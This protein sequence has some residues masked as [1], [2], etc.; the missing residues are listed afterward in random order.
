METSRIGF[1]G[2]PDVASRFEDEGFSVVTGESV[3]AS[4]KAIREALS[5]RSPSDSPLPVIVEDQ[6][7]TGL[8][9]LLLRFQRAAGDAAIVVVRSDEEVL[10]HDWTDIPLE[11]T[12]LEYARAAGITDAPG[13][14]A[15]LLVQ[16]DGSVVEV[17][18]D[19]DEPGLDD[20]DF[21]DEPAEPSLDDIDFGD[22][23]PV[24]AAPATA[25]PAPVAPVEDE[26]DDPF[27][28]DEPEPAPRR[29]STAPTAPSPAPAPAQPSLS[30][31]IF[32]AEEGLAGPSDDGDLRGATSSP[33]PAPRR[34][35]SPVP[36]IEEEDLDAE[37][38]PGEIGRPEEESA[39]RTRSGISRHEEVALSPSAR[40]WEVAQDDAPARPADDG[41]GRPRRRVVSA[42]T[43]AAEDP[44]GLSAD[45]SDDYLD[46]DSDDPDFADALVDEDDDDDM[47][48]G[49][50]ARRTA[51]SRARSARGRAPVIFNG[52][53]KGGVGK[54]LLTISLGQ[55]AA[56]RGQGMDVCV[57]D[58]NRGQG[59]VSTFLKLRRSDLPT[60]FEAAQVGDVTKAFLS[61]S[62][63]E[64][65]RGD[66]A[67]H[68]RFTLVSAPR[69]N[70][71]AESAKVVTD[72]TY[73]QVIDYARDNFDLVI[74]DTQIVES[75]D[76][77]GLIDGVVLPLLAE[78]AYFL[79]ITD[80]SRAGTDNLVD[81][82]FRRFPELGERHFGGKIAPR[83]FM[84][85]VNRMG[86]DVD[87]EGFERKFGKMSNFAGA[88]PHDERV[89]DLMN[90]GQ[91]P[92]DLPRV[93]RALDR[94]LYRVTGADEFH[95]DATSGRD[96]DEEQ[97]EKVGL[98]ARLFGWR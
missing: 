27:E 54:T 65:V 52:S 41:G 53:G 59:D 96:D 23:E 79:G 86:R 56:V 57:I 95:P 50:S 2:I 87:P 35:I 24:A 76:T 29:A 21:G 9:G 88:V 40:E 84:T 44:R 66:N 63:L 97:T 42:P 38:T 77:S 7:Q 51:R 69:A 46:S 30:E 11:S 83:N 85:I 19:E 26:E 32:D 73:R 48:L 92:H 55:R 91:V 98:F 80:Q 90:A 37:L 5:E 93:A 89:R 75:S 62:R 22:D 3:I 18:L 82:I 60:I 10:P 78:G 47:L 36:M 72:R 74:V 68:I 64:A 43:P 33:A 4:A 34:R 20:I 6:R 70:D 39:P 14:L 81:H 31:E 71:A 67:E 15:R 16:P 45:S 28:D 12:L 25:A 13:S 94:V 17:E 1:I 8:A 61:P 58:M 49:R